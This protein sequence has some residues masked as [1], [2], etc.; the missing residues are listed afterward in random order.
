[1]RNLFLPL[2]LVSLASLSAAAA[3][4][5][6][7]FETPVYTNASYSTSQP[8]AVAAS[9]SDPE[10]AAPAAAAAAGAGVIRAVPM[11]MSGSVR[12]FSGVGL[13]V[14][15][16]TTGIGFDLST[17]LAQ[18]FALRTGASFFSYNTSLTES[19][20]NVDGN[21]HLQSATASLD[22]Y[23]FRHNS[24][25]LSPGINFS[26]HN[27]VA[28]HPA[29]P[30]RS[31]LLLRR[32]RN[33]LQLRHRPRPRHR[34]LHLRQPLR[35]AHDRRLGQHHAARRRPRQR[36]ARVRLPVHR[37]TDRL[38]ERNRQLLW[39]PGPG[40]RLNRKRL[41]PS[42]S[43]RRR[44]G[45]ERAP[46]RHLH[47]PLLPGRLDRRQLPHRRRP[48]LGV[49]SLLRRDQQEK[50]PADQQGLSRSRAETT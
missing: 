42:R 28:G 27:R 4:A 12:P 50:A 20:I 7:S 32:W 2:G 17:P 21:L 13:A 48:P 29:R 40:R 43:D 22:I 33:L 41:R 38:A 44:P 10:P 5:Q 18:H 47:A 14:K 31:D 24:F 19:G 49:T 3:S 35:P 46:E 36:A 39:Q 45:A 30:R 9:S 16:G 26:N 11:L 25:R 1:M 15:V 34:G 23:P 6:V 8:A 37:T